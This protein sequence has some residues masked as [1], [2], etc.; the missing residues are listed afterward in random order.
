M[1][2]VSSQ[3]SGL[4]SSGDSNA[5]VVA[6]SGGGSSQQK[7]Y[8]GLDF[9]IIVDFKTAPPV[10]VQLVA[11]TMQEKAAWT[12]DISQVTP[13]SLVP[14]VRNARVATSSSVDGAAARAKPS[15]DTPLAVP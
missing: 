4:G 14:R 15:A 8:G 9:K 6:P 2:S 10:T 13:T 3:S 11:P 1:S 7:D 5:V 12:S